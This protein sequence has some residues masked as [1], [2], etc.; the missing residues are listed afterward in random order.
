MDN[1]TLL[2]KYKYRYGDKLRIVLEDNQVKILQSVLDEVSG[3]FY[4]RATVLSISIKELK[5]K[6]L[7]HDNKIKAKL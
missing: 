7:E 4:P 1:R 3:K 2:L 6:I 5:E